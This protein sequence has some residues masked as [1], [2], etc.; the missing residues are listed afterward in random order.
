MQKEAHQSEKRRK[1]TIQFGTA[2][3]AVG[4]LLSSNS[5]SATTHPLVAD[6]IEQAKKRIPAIVAEQTEKRLPKALIIKAAESN[7]KIWIAHRSHSSHRSH[8]SHS[9]HSSHYSSS[10][11]SHYSATTYVP[12]PQSSTPVAPVSAPVAIFTASVTKGIVPLM[13][14][15]SDKSTGDLMYWKWNFGDGNTSMRRNPTHTYN[16]PGIYTVTL[17]VTGH[18][19]RDTKTLKDYIVVSEA[20]ISIQ[21]PKPVT[22]FSVSTTQG[23][24]PLTIYFTDQSTGDII[25]W[26]WDFGDNHTSTEQNPI[27]IYE[28]PGT[29]T[30]K[31]KT[32]GPGGDTTKIFKDY[33]EVSSAPAIKPVDSLPESTSEYKER[34]KSEEDSG[35]RRWIG[36]I[37]L[38]GVGGWLLGKFRG[39]SKKK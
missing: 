6:M 3:F 28:V 36:Y 19:G 29:Y 15:F 30:V 18:G 34:S 39:R 13:V 11:A 35:G 21:K 10:H 38:A 14:D 4:S 1:L 26:E 7:D 24:V 32:T 23:T 31:L 27:H 9:S 20:P 2:A 5:V 33:I 16:V 17:T 22:A 12:S 25:S 37:L 8:A